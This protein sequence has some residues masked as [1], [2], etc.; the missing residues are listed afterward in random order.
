MEDL[1][2][3]G[4]KNKRLNTKT[5][6]G[7]SF[8]VTFRR[9]KIVQNIMAKNLYMLYMTDE[10]KKAFIPKPMISYRSSF[11]ISSYLVRAKLYPINRTV[12]CYKCGSKRC[13][14]CK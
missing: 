8:A 13:E 2:L 9:L 1:I 3:S 14:V 12:G 4:D 10:V 7:I 5:E 6:K 11:K